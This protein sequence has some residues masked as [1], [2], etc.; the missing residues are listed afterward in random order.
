MNPS[1]PFVSRLTPL[2]FA[3][4]YL[5]CSLLLFEYEIV[6]QYIFET[7]TPNYL[8]T[9]SLKDIVMLYLITGN[10]E[11][12]LLKNVLQMALKFTNSK[13]E[14][15][16]NGWSSIKLYFGKTKLQKI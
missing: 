8:Y 6:P 14:Q 7:I 5:V 13:F 16:T 12:K 15:I 4:N 11:R 10:I 3:K 1:S 2:H 9:G